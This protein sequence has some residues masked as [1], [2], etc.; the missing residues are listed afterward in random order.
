MQGEFYTPAGQLFAF[1]VKC[2]FLVKELLASQRL[3]TL[4][5]I[6][7]LLRLAHINT[8]AA[9]AAAAAC[10]LVEL[11]N[12]PVMDSLRYQGPGGAAAG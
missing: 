6:A 5:P 1:G 12:R 2:L 7:Y 9:A 4:D 3:F 11:T 10:T 8:S